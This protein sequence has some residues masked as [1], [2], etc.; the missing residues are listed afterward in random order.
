MIRRG[1]RITSFGVVYRGAI[2]HFRI[3][4]PRRLVNRTA[5]AFQCRRAK[6][7]V[8][9]VVGRQQETV[10]QGNARFRTWFHR[11]GDLGGDTRLDT[12]S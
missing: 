6:E 7:H 3:F 4:V 8:L 10:D 2:Q 11:G 5:T 9:M 1:G 12:H